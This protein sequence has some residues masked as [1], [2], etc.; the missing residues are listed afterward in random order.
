MTIVIPM[1]GRGERFLQAGFPAPKMLIEAQGKK[2]L[3]WGVDSLPLEECDQLI[4]VALQEHEDAFGLSEYISDWYREAAPLD[5]IFLPDYNCGQVETVLAARSLIE[6]DEPL[7]IFGLE[8]AFDSPTLKGL[9]ADEMNDGVLGTFGSTDPRFSYAATNAQGIV[10]R[11]AVQEPISD[12]ALTGLF[13]FRR[14]QDFLEVATEAVKA[15]ARTKGEFY[16]A[17][18]YNALI[19]RGYR[20]V[21]DACADYRSIGTP[22]EV[23]EFQN[24]VVDS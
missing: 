9:L 12:H 6:P 20:F 16:V 13:H 19:T 15:N 17:P 14:A 11:V 22:E 10:T 2:L 21:L 1:A 8:T 23:A 18:M 5:F 3:Q 24:E 4:F 7:L